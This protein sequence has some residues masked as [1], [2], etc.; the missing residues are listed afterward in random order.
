MPVH[1]IET[2]EDFNKV[3]KENPAVVVDWFATWCA[4]CKAIA[5]KLVDHSN[6]EQFKDVYFAKVDVDVL[7]KLALEYGVTA[8]PTFHLFKNGEKVDELR[9]ANPP[10]LQS[11]I[12]KAL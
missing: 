2:T 12:A 8:M 1:N 11:L 5:P 3:I 9:G 7:D 6:E 4:P 10:A